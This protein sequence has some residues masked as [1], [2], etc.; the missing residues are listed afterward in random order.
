MV[1][2]GTV[3]KSRNGFGSGKPKKKQRKEKNVLAYLSGKWEGATFFPVLM[4]DHRGVEL[5]EELVGVA[6]LLKLSHP[7]R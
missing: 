7:K 5:I 1:I 6:Q 3:H 2:R 4:F